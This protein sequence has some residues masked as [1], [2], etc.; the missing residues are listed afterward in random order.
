MTVA[1]TTDELDENQLQPVPVGTLAGGGQ[2]RDLRFVRLS[3]GSVML[4]KR[5]TAE[6]LLPESRERPAC[7][8]S[9]GGAVSSARRTG[10]RSTPARL[11]YSMSSRTG[12]ARSEC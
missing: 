12:A 1:V 4:F 11:G 7:A 8:R 2:S 10:A 5:H 9:C 6:S 3:D